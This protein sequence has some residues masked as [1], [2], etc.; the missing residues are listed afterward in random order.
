[1]AEIGTRAAI[2]PMT[3]TTAARGVPEP[4]CGMGFTLPRLPSMTLGLKPER[5]AG[6]RLGLWASGSFMTSRA[7][8]RL[9]MRLRK[10]RSSRARMRRWMPDL[11]WRSEERRVGEGGREG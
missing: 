11:D 6:D 4:A 9:G 10:P 8:A 3:G 2:R 1:M 7:R 5:L